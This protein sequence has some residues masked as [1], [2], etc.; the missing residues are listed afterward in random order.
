MV[1]ALTEDLSSRVIGETVF[2]FGERRKCHKTYSS[3]WPMISM[4]MNRTSAILRS[5]VALSRGMILS[6][7]VDDIHDRRR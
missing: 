5:V 3:P 7:F 1:T 4:G 2:L 6:S